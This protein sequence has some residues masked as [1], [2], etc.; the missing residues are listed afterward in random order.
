MLIPRNISLI[1]NYIID[2]RISSF[3]EALYL[4][5]MVKRKYL[6]MLSKA[7]ILH[8]YVIPFA[9]RRLLPRNL[10]NEIIDL[11]WGYVLKDFANVVEAKQDIFKPLVTNERMRRKLFHDFNTIYHKPLLRLNVIDSESLGYLKELN[12]IDI[13]RRSDNEKGVFI[14]YNVRVPWRI[15]RNLTIRSLPVR[16]IDIRALGIKLGIQRR[17][18]L[19]E[20]LISDFVNRVT[21]Q[22]IPKVIPYIT[23]VYSYLKPEHKDFNHQR[24]QKEIAEFIANRYSYKIHAIENGRYHLLINRKLLPQGILIQ[25]VSRYKSIPNLAIIYDVKRRYGITSLARLLIYQNSL[26]QPVKGWNVIAWNSRKTN[27]RYIPRK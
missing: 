19:S 10:R 1:I 5:D 15:K 20:P 16:K 6:S 27:W 24:L 7:R 21:S 17:I 22:N 8:S 11:G 23:D 4:I 9:R 26:K 2:Q 18:F 13:V 12:A 14:T 3:E 25:V